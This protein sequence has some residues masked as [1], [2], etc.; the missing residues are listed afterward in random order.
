LRKC[1]EIDSSAKESVFVFNAF[2]I[3][4]SSSP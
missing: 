1:A 3:G 2:A 4:I